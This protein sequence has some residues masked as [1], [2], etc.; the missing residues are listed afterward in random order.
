MTYEADG[1]T[2]ASKPEAMREFLLDAI[3]TISATSS[4]SG[5]AVLQ[6][7]REM[8]PHSLVKHGF[9]K[10]LP[11]S[12]LLLTLPLFLFCFVHRA[13]VAACIK[14]KKENTC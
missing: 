13:N 5:E 8:V 2:T 9:P 10:V 3:P 14:S 1:A 4:S 7:V 6:L 12:F 11:A